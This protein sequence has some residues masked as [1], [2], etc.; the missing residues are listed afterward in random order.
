MFLDKVNYVIPEVMRKR[1]LLS[2]L[3]LIF[4]TSSVFA[5]A[6]APDVLIYNGKIYDL[7][8]NPL[9]DFYRANKSKRPK[10]WV[11]PNV[12]SSGNWR[13]Y[14]A[15]WEIIDDKL[16]LTKIDSW[17]CRSSTQAKNGCRRVTLRDLF[18]TNVIDGKVFASWFSD[19][20]QAPDGKQ[21]KYVHS[22]YASIYERDMFFDVEAGKIVKQETIDNTK[23]EL[24]SDQE[25][26]QQELARL[27]K[28]A[29]EEKNI[30]LTTPFTSKTSEKVEPVLIT[31][32]G[33]GKV[34]VGAKRKVIEAVLGKGGHDGHKY[35]DVY[36]VEYPQKGVQISYINKRDE[37]HAI[38][39][40]NKQTYYSDFV[41]APVKTDK[42]IT[43]D[44]SPEDIIEAYGKPPRDFRDE[45]GN[46]A[47]RRLEYDK[48]DF[49][50]QQ[51]RM[52]RI[53]VSPKH[54][55]GCE[56]ER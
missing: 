34:V 43:W 33:W 39:F 42:G 48:I 53:S 56:K 17:F 13:G 2:L 20:L 19:K 6:Q 46:N 47:W 14:V 55:T 28:K 49:L 27:K 18:G 9:E 15:T 50:F 22:G 3:S 30:P 31:E 8:S 25:I 38:F 11:A 10:F 24:P 32:N 12:M 41:T 21:L 23:R 35:E 26:F 1:I 5:T 40:Y 52:T 51:G 16:Y 54:C 29:S 37:A 7:Y 4:I 36:F 44:S 45:T